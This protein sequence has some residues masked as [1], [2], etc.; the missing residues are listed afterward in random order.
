MGD[1]ADFVVVDAPDPMQ[2]LRDIAPVLL[3]FKR[4]R[5][6]FTRPQAVLHPPQG[7]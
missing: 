1:P 5:R 7:G 2:A 6:A 3:G 4:G